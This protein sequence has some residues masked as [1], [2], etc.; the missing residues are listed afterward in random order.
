M[1]AEF[2]ESGSKFY[3]NYVMNN[4][5]ANK[6][7]DILSSWIAMEVLSPQT[8]RKPQDLAGAM[9][10]IAHFDAPVL[11]WEGDGEKSKPNYRLYYQVIIGT[12]DY[13]KAIT[14]LVDVYVDK[15][16]ERPIPKG[17]AIIA[18]VI[19]DNKGR[20]VNDPSVYV[21]SFAWGLPKALKK[22]LID[23]SEWKSA[24]N[25][26]RMA[27][28]KI[29][30]RT[31][32]EGKELPLDSQAIK[33]AKQYLIDELKIPL[34][35]VT[36][37]TF[38]VRTYQ[39]YSNAEPP[40]SLFLNS[41]YIDDLI[42]A[43]DLF[44]QSKVS[45]NLQRYMGVKHLKDRK[46]LLHD[47]NALENAIAP[48]MMP[49]ARWPGSGR[50]PLVVLQ[51]AAVN[52]A[53][54]ELKTG[55]IL[56]VNGPPGTGKTTLLRDIVAGIVTNRAEIMCAFDDPAQAFTN[57]NEKISA[58]KGWLNLYKLDNSLKGFEILV[59]SSNN[60]A[61]ENVSTELPALKAISNDVG[62]LRYFKSLSDALLGRESWGLIAAVLGNATNR[63]RF[64][65]SFWW[66]AEVG[67]STYLA[68]AAG[69][70]QFIDIIDDK[71][72]KVIGTRKPLI[73]EKEN[74]PGNRAEAIERWK[75][76]KDK[77]QSALVKSRSELLAIEKIREQ[78][79][80][81]P[82]LQKDEAEARRSLKSAI[83]KES[84]SKSNLEACGHICA[85]LENLSEEAEQSL[86][87]HIKIRPGFF[88]RIFRTST[89]RRWKQE[90]HVH[91]ENAKTAQNELDNSITQL[92]Q[93][94]DIVTNSSDA[95]QQYKNTLSKI[96]KKLSV[97]KQNIEQSRPTLGEH[98][99]DDNFF[100]LSHELKH[101]KSPWC[102]EYAQR[103]RDDVFIEAIRL[104][105][106]FIDASAKEIRHNLG[107]LMMV[108]S[109]RPMP[110]EKKEELLP[111]LWSTLFLV[112]P[113]LSTTF[114]SV[115]RM[116]GK[117]PAQSLGW[118]LIDEAGQ[119][120]PQAAVGA[121]IRTKR[122]VIVGDP[123]QIE[124]VVTLPGALTQNICRQFGVD[125][126][127][128][129]APEASAQTLA[130]A[131]TPYYAS[132]EGR[133]GSRFVGVPLLVHRRCE[134]P[135]FSISN[136][137]AYERL[138]VQA[139]KP[140]SSRIKEIMGDSR[141]IDVKG[142][143]QDKWCPEEGVVV[144]D[145]L[146]RLRKANVNPDLY[147]V[148]PFVIVADNLRK[149]M[150]DSGILESWVG[151]DALWPYERIGTVHT[152]QGREAEAVIFVLGAP[153]PQQTGARNWAGGR[154]NLLNVAVT[155]AKESLYVIGNRQL[156]Q[157]AGLFS[158]LSSRLP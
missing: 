21:S 3:F 73:I 42:L 34:Q 135:M 81:V 17:E 151:N 134:E 112:V 99:I 137:I 154:P 133:H 132:F 89:A 8:F 82:R 72:R 59:A 115:E 147:I 75:K 155:R 121:I 95:I 39:Y 25:K 128:F 48:S 113:G 85:K 12:I 54:K 87:D 79:I 106:A 53:F 97:I 119:A 116:F 76:A 46:D 93:L 58:G 7:A 5:F 122:A 130:D 94:R 103:L 16:V 120:L 129:N 77:F 105:K 31:D 10:S 98:M 22:N 32:E 149:L 104:H 91:I 20:L 40:E 43:K 88:A 13:E 28:D 80:N 55:G 60:K 57:S 65:Q 2:G 64:K 14:S 9:G 123:V 36:D 37:S 18:V 15:R 90:Y 23:L 124:P 63:N 157:N 126:D 26:L 136:T 38:A 52:L 141:W 74:P 108:F 50:H 111:D 27:I 114:A 41:F 145:I 70:P 4:S 68:E 110:D 1:D 152:V 127:R 11:P 125:P 100:T 56:A 84:S 33:Q 146:H 6:P 61:V 66:D 143:A 69:T 142:Q 78:I 107:V 158:E 44:K 102:D 51:Q 19:V 30:R 29:T 117:L 156:W 49:A 62:D 86:S 138:M 47:H 153:Q 35:Y 144:L 45:Q 139:K 92:T 118:L 148:T 71:T 109:G 67:L 131:A 140:G 96:S 101:V 24:E 150:R 83:T